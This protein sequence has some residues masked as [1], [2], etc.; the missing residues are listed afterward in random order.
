MKLIGI[1]GL[2]SSRIF[3]KQLVRI[4][5]YQNILFKY[6]KYF[7]LGGKESYEN[8]YSSWKEGI[9]ELRNLIST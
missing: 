2:I 4:H 9:E 3:Y 8:L 6:R 7:S 5:L 1:L